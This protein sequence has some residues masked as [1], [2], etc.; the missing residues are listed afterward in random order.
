MKCASA[1]S[2][3]R[4][5][6]TA[7]LPYVYL[8]RHFGHLA[9]VYL[10]ADI[11]ARYWRARGRDVLFV[12]GTDENAATTILEARRRSLPP[13]Q[14][15]DEYHPFQEHIFRRL[16]ISFDI[17]SRTSR[18]VHHQTIWE[19]YKELD[20]KGLIYKGE[21]RQPFCQSCE[22]YLPDRF[23]RGRCPRCGAEEQYGDSCEVC[24]QWFDPADLVDATCTLCGSKPI[25][26]N[27][28][29]S[30]FRLSALEEK[31]AKYA[32]TEG[33]S[34]R[35]RTYHK[36]ISWLEEDGLRD[37]DITRDYDWGPRAP[38]LESGQVIYNWAENL[39]GYISA[40]K[41]WAVSEKRP[42]EWS[43]WWKEGRSKIVCFLGKDN[44]FF[45]TILF[46][47]LLLG[48]GGLNLPCQIVVNEFVNL[49]RSKMSTSRGNV[50]WLHNLLETLDPEIIRYYAAA[51]APEK[52][53]TVFS[54]E[55]LVKRVNTD[56]ANNIGNLVNRV[57]VLSDKILGN[58]PVVGEVALCPNQQGLIETIRKAE[59]DVAEYLGKFEFK[60][61]LEE[62]IELSRKGNRF[63]NQTKPWEDGEGSKV[64]IWSLLK[65]LGSLAVLLHPFLPESAER[66]W[67]QLGH[68]RTIEEEGWDAALQRAPVK[69]ITGRKILFK[70]ILLDG[71]K[72]SSS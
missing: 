69:P 18:L 56:L 49:S 57:L 52:K 40:T 20:E 6:V 47:A 43:V 34:W 50:V 3:S 13:K 44:L 53:D 24:A 48:H 33:R 10:P 7:A 29:H 17:F 63:L 4:I 38:F 8:P 14:L 28:K 65:L 32:E 35:K 61:A 21:V 41:D 23:V 27:V 66:I 55:D 64:T 11:Y 30:F 5:L 72:R 9:G 31:V 51:I 26:R 45:N 42:E 54:W 36:T 71:V 70:K 1:T 59:E 39:L 19:F 67:R 60:R 25:Y 68:S 46:P 12:C 62:V 2:P 22:E 16:G 58:S 37:K 15:C